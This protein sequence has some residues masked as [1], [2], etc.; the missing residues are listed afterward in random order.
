MTLHS[1][2]IEHLEP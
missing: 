2:K 1:S